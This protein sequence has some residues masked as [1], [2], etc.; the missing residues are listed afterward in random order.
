MNNNDLNCAI[1]HIM[2]TVVSIYFSG[3]EGRQQ[4]VA[5]E[6]VTVPKLF[7][8]LRTKAW[9]DFFFALQLAVLEDNHMQSAPFHTQQEKGFYIND[10]KGSQ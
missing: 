6:T 2:E 1:L 9:S 7:H 5:T 4:L 8:K 3:E 10:T